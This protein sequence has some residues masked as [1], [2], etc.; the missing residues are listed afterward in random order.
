MGGFGEG[1]DA[2]GV[3]RMKQLAVLQAV[4]LGTRTRAPFHRR[5]HGF[6]PLNIIKI[7]IVYVTIRYFIIMS[8]YLTSIREPSDWMILMTT[9][10]GMQIIEA[11]ARDQPNPIDQSG[12]SYSLL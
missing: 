12:Y 6:D 4:L 10:I 9:I 7:I 11:S 5:R 2:V 8:F 1:V 3:Q